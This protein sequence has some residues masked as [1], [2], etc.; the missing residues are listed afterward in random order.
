MCAGCKLC[1]LCL[2]FVQQVVIT[3]KQQESFQGN[4][5]HGSLEGRPGTG[6]DAPTLQRVTFDP[7]LTQAI[8]QESL[9]ET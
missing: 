5:H 9:R 8:S 7:L 2:S 6:A 4:S 3:V 1:I